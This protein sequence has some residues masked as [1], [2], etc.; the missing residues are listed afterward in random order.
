MSL[1]PAVL[2]A[3]L[4]GGGVGLRLD[5]GVHAAVGNLC[6]AIPPEDVYFVMATNV[7][8]VGHFAR[9]SRRSLPAGQVATDLLAADPDFRTVAV[10]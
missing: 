2:A 10:K 3:L 9:R 6:C 1:K 5:E 4:D 7:V 8:P